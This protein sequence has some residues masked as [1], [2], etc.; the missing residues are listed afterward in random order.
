[1]PAGTVPGFLCWTTGP[2][3]N[4]VDVWFK[5]YWNSATG[6]YASGDDNSSYTTDSQITS[7]YGIPNCGGSSPSTPT[8]GGG[9]A[10]PPSSAT[11]NAGIEAAAAN[12]ARAQAGSTAW[13]YRCLTFVYR[14]WEAAGLSR[15]VLNSIAGFVPNSDT[16]PI[17]QWR[18]WTSGHP[19]GG[20]WHDGF[21]PAPPT[22]AMIFYSNKL[23]D[24]DSHA[25]VSLGGGSMI[26]PGTRGVTGPVSVTYNDYA[27]MLGWWM[28][29]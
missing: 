14:A 15:S 6:Y 26:S 10:A 24:E 12:W 28:P 8:T 29:R 18:Y 23:G 7:K 9:G 5:V 1:M 2:V 11:G 4:G 25:T 3:T 16:Y 27:T 20:I 22:G 19:P 13:E 17:D 21:D